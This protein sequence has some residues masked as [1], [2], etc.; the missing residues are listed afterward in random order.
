LVE[1]GVGEHLAWA[2]HAVADDDVFERARRDVA[3]EGFDRAPE[4][5]CRFGRGARPIRWALALMTTPV[6]A[7]T[8]VPTSTLI[9][10]P[11]GH[12]GAV[13][14]KLDQQ[15]FAG[16]AVHPSHEPGR[17]ARDLR[18]D[19]IAR[20]LRPEGIACELRPEGECFVGWCAKGR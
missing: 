13:P 15:L 12:V 3:V 2:L 9:F 6:L 7:K 1:I 11:G 10:D 20:M 17:I 8:G 16:N 18:L 4:L 14:K 5:R 19:G